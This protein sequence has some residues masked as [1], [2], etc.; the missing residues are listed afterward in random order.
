MSVFTTVTPDQLSAWLRNYSIG[1]LTDLQGIAAGIENTNY[2]VSTT[3]G[4]FVLTLF[5]KLK[6]AELPFYLKLMAHLSSHGI[7]CPKPIANLQNAYLG[8]LNGKPAAIA[9][10][11]SGA[12]ELDPTPEHCA[13]VGEVLAEMHLSGQTY[14]GHLENLRGPKWWAGC[15]PEIYPFL[16][17]A[18]A[19][20]L[21]SE[22]RFQAEHRHDQLPRG[23]I[24]ADL[25]RDNVLFHEGAVGGF[26][27]FYFA[28]VDVLIYDVAIAV[29]DWCSTTDCGLDLARTQALLEAYCMV[30]P[31]TDAEREAWPIMLRAGAL[32]FWVSRLYDFHLPR[33]GALT[34]AHDP[35]RFRRI[36][37]HHVNNARRPSSLS[38]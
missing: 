20:L 7:P 26:I 21:Q 22:I 4:R 28:C 10:C 31:L 17:T 9:T 16:S 11:L 36:L 2:F 33:A 12:P 3:H 1:L 25:F 35:E 14:K 13:R 24:H 19:E 37:L 5:E 27:D 32:R 15:A 6:P 8:A 18:D 23:V 34:H 30:R 38:V 29:N